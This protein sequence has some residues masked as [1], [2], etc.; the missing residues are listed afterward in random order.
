MT[1]TVSRSTLCRNTVM[2]TP[3]SKS[4]L[5]RIFLYS[6]ISPC[7]PERAISAAGIGHKKAAQ[8]SS[9]C[10]HSFSHG[11]VLRITLSG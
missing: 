7:D 1:C 6:V 10:S 9:S 5:I 3:I 2:T 11:T 8:L 4:R